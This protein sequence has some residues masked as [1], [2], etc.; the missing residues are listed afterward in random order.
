MVDYSFHCPYFKL[1]FLNY[2]T[3]AEHFQLSKHPKRGV[4]FGS[5]RRKIQKTPQR[6]TAFFTLKPRIFYQNC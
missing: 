1:F 6:Q 4:L 2:S 3:E 5:L